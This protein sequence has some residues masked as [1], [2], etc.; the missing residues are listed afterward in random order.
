VAN[1]GS[2][3][4]S[5]DRRIRDT[6]RGIEQKQFPPVEKISGLRP[7]RATGSRNLA[8]ETRYG[9]RCRQSVLVVERDTKEIT[10]SPNQAAPPD[11]Q[12]I[13][14]GQFEAIWQHR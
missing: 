12:K 2:Q 9:G 13:I 3:D 8:E 6:E 14:E 11:R 10:V 7:P 4:G 5:H 1:R